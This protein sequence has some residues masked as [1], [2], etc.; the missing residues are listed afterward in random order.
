MVP[1]L[2]P[3]DS[4]R[5]RMRGL[6]RYV[7]EERGFG[8]IMMQTGLRQEDQRDDVFCHIRDVKQPNGSSVSNE[9]FERMRA[10][11]AI[12]EFDL[13]KQ[14][15]GRDRAARVLPLTWS[16]NPVRV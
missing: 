6:L 5:P 12:L 15:D 7:E 10:H 8:F 2:T 1:G 11:G 16:G 13:E 14:E 9:E 4:E 3:Q